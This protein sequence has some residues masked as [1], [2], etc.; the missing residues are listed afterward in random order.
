MTLTTLGRINVPVSGTPVPIT[1]NL[2]TR[3]C[4]VLF[5]AVPGLTG[6]GYIGTP[7]MNIAALTGVTRVLSPNSANGIA[8]TYEIIA[9]D[10]TD[11]IPLAQLAIDMQVA[12]EGML[13]SYWVE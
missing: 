6:K 9:A 11:S 12:G 5:Q 1:A 7:Q 2:K 4:R 3:A 13:V 8:E 10:G